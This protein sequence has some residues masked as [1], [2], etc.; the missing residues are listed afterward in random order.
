MIN[1]LCEI[2]DR[3]KPFDLFSAR[4]V[5]EGSYH[6]QPPTRPTGFAQKLILRFI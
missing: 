6:G 1:C 4:A 2:F 3:Q 5:V